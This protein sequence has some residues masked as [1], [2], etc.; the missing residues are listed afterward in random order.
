MSLGK[1]NGGIVSKGDDKASRI[2][3]EA[4]REGGSRMAVRWLARNPV[5]PS[6]A[7][8]SRPG[9][10]RGSRGEP[11]GGKKQNFRTNRRKR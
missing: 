6:Y 1:G 4:E 10:A 9:F 3:G 7:P 11:D 5:P 2:P 8:G